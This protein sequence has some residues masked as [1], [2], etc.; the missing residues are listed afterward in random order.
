MSQI[1]HAEDCFS[2]NAYLKA[3]VVDDTVYHFRRILPDTT[4]GEIHDER[5]E[6]SVM[7]YEADG[8][9]VTYR[10]NEHV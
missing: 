10:P 2:T 7:V 8:S 9:V 3:V 4:D 1:I 6:S 5:F